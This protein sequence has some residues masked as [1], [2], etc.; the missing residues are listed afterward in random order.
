MI[1]AKRTLNRSKWAGHEIQR[2]YD[3][4]HRTVKKMRVEDYGSITCPKVCGRGD[5]GT[6]VACWQISYYFC[7][8]PAWDNNGLS[9]FNRNLWPNKWYLEDSMMHLITKHSSWLALIWS[10][11]DS[12]SSDWECKKCHCLP[13]ACA[14]L[15]TLQTSGISW[16]LN[17]PENVWTIHFMLF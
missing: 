6:V 8:L 7:L 2:K 13:M 4:S 3:V 9:M 17:L 10:L 16:K 15:G 14:S 1:N 5:T 11:E 12:A